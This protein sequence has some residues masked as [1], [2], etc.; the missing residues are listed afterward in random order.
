MQNQYI[1]MQSSFNKAISANY[2]ILHKIAPTVS[3]CDGMSVWELFVKLN[4]ITYVGLE[5]DLLSSLV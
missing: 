5:A 2:L 4:L 3:L 1:N